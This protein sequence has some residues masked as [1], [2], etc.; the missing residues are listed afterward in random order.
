MDNQRALHRHVL[1]HDEL[2]DCVN[3]PK[4]RLELHFS[5]G[6]ILIGRTLIPRQ[7]V[8]PL[9]GI[10]TRRFLSQLHLHLHLHLH[11]RL[12]CGAIYPYTR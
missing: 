5:P 10:D 8:G 12:V 1:V 3:A 2:I 4:F 11:L 6:N 7:V 9:D